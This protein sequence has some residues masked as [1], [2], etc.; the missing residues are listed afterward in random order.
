MAQQREAEFFGYN[1]ITFSD[2]IFGSVID[3]CCDGVD[4]IEEVLLR[5]PELKGKEAAI[6]KGA[7]KLLESLKEAFGKNFDTFELYTLKY[8][9]HIPP[10]IDITNIPQKIDS[11]SEGRAKRRRRDEENEEIELDKEIESLRREIQSKQSEVIELR[12]KR[13]AMQ[14][15]FISSYF[16]KLHL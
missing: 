7:D 2:D 3:Y 9:F 1:P 8:I 13:K 6:K 4:S 11:A 16:F 5:N 10:D 12:G 15:Y 14:V